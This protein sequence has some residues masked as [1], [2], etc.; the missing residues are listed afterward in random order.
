MGIL[1]N[2]IL[3]IDSDSGL[4]RKLYGMFA[5]AETRV[6]YCGTLESAE[7]LLKKNKY[8]VIIIDPVLPDGNGY[9][10]VCR[11]GSGIC[12]SGAAVILVLENDKKFDRLSVVQALYGQWI[13]DYITKPF[14]PL[15]LKAKVWSQ[16]RRREKDSALRA[17]MRFEAIGA[18]TR[19]S[20][21]GEHMVENDDYSFN[22]DT[23]EYRV[24][25]ETV[26]LNRLEQCLLRN[27]V[28]NKGIVLGR[29]ALMD[30]LMYESRIRVDEGKLA[31]TVR[32]LT[33]KLEAYGCLKTV[34]GIG[35]IWRDT[36]DKSI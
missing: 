16:F 21:A 22:F 32:G 14:N 23:G 2:K 26:H 10:L 20:I 29:K 28:E 3:I 7:V 4:D 8:Q 17:S 36:E 1:M 13:V 9:D 24:H 19:S 18:G 5:D 11:L 33:E 31:R 34:Y 25:G 6:F 35:Y 27:L 12:N 15:V 30:K